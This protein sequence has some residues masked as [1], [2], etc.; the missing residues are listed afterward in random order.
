MVFFVIM[1]VEIVVKVLGILGYIDVLIICRLVV[2]WMWKFE[3]RIVIG[4]LLVL[5]G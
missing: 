5:M 2:L 3:F 4:L 1:Y